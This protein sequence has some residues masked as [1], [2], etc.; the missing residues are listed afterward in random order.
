MLLKD[1]R[2]LRGQKPKAPFGNSLLKDRGA[3][4]SSQGWLF[5]THV[6]SLWIVVVF[7]LLLFSNIDFF[8]KLI[9]GENANESLYERAEQNLVICLVHPLMLQAGHGGG[10]V[11]PKFTRDVTEKCID[12][13]ALVNEGENSVFYIPSLSHSEYS[14]FVST[15]NPQTSEG[16]VNILAMNLA[17]ATRFR[18]HFEEGLIT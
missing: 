6:I 18:G 5:Q 15:L 1:I 12:S 13:A 2:L 7:F 8:V 17:L 3:S 4:G 16:Q 14:E 9:F 10:T 11:Y